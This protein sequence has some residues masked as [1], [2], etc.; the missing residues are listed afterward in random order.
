MQGGRISDLRLRGGWGLLGNPAVP[1]YASLILL[2]PSGGARYVFGEQAVTGV[3]PVRNPNPN[4]KWEE[5]A[6]FNVALDYGLLRNRFFGTI[7]YYIKNTKDLLLTVPV[8]QP[9]LVSERLE[10]IGKVSNRGLELSLDAC[11]A[12]QLLYGSDAPVIGT[13]AT[14]HA[15]AELGEGVR[16][17]ILRENPTRLFA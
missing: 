9:A 14:L 12:G 17:T 13:R 7:E 6:Q 10:N 2:E 16:R 8:S 5:T 15:V 11:G 3:A 1:P 4:L